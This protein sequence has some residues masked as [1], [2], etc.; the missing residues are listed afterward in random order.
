MRDPRVPIYI[1]AIPLLPIIY[2]L[3]PLDFI[4]DVIP[5]IGQLDDITLLVLGMRFME[6]VAP[7]ELVQEHRLAIERGDFARKD[8][9]IDGKVK[10]TK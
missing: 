9:V 5:V 3:S 10:R 2:L 1:K 4:P 6:S 8:D 7:Q